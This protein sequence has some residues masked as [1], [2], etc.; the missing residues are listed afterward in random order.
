M[1]KLKLKLDY[2]QAQVLSRHLERCI[3]N[4]VGNNLYEQLLGYSLAEVSARLYPF[5]LGGGAADIKLS[6]SRP[7]A[8]AIKIAIAA[9]EWPGTDEDVVL[10]MVQQQLPKTIVRRKQDLL[11]PIICYEED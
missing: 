8:T 10:F 11:A 1:K 2:E 4:I 9:V 5:L 7:E 6:L 3:V